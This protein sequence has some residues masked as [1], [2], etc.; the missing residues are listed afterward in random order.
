MALEFCQSSHVYTLDSQVVPSVTGVLRASGIIDF[1]Q[2][3]S[4]ML[5]AAL[6]R[7]T[8]VHKALHYHAERDLDVSQFEADFP[9]YAG[10]LR[11]G[12]S[13][14]G[15]RDV[16]PVLLE[17]RVASRKHRV[18]GTIDFLGEMSGHGALIDWA[19]GDPRDSGKSLQTAAYH[20]LALEWASEDPQLAAFIARHKVVRRYSVRLKKDGSLPQPTPYTDPF[21]YSQFLTLVSARRIVEQH[22]GEVAAW[23]AA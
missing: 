13:F 22:K 15:R 20:G 4:D 5:A 11:S 2:A 18:A 7:G 16:V 12:L 14:L 17:H 9:D 8:V 19:T 21:D 23:M 1:S 10:Y 6:E 3:P